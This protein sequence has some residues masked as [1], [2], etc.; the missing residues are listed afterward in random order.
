M[1]INYLTTAEENLMNIMWRLDS[2]YMKEVLEQYVEPKPHQNT[3]STFMKILVEKDFQCLDKTTEDQ[4]DF[5][6]NPNTTCK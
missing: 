1:K 5:F 6:V 3:I 2:A 4:S